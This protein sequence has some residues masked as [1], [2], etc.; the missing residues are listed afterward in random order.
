[1]AVKHG[2]G[3]KNELTLQWAEMRMIRWM[4]AVKVT[5]SFMYRELTERLA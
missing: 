5:D 3:R 1:M 2:Q 4:C